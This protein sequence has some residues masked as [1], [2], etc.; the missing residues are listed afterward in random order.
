M[1]ADGTILVTGGSRGIG[2]ATASLLADQ[3]HRV[4]I[5]DIAPEPLAGTNAI[6]WPAPFDVASEAAVV[7]GVADIEKAHGPITG[8]VNAAGVFGKMHPIERVRMEQWDREV[9]IDLRGTFLVAR[10]VGVAMAKRR[11]GAIVN[12]ASVAGMTSGPIHAYT[13]AKAGVIQIT[14][15]LAAEWGRA[16]VRVNAVSPGFTRT[17]MLEA[18]IASGALDK[19]LLARPTAMNRLVEPV[20]VAQAIAWLLSPLSSGVTGI[21]LPVDAGYIA[22]T[23]WAA[24]GGLPDA[25]AD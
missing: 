17:A 13:A 12:V 22:G 14:Q 1:S 2:A 24:Y 3:G 23:S 15:T 16:G 9:N 5:V 4:V 18:G 8:L 20:E 19:E 10:S 21:N 11:H 25:P 7:T 6:L